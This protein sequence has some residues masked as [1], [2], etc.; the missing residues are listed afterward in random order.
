MSSIDNLARSD[1]SIKHGYALVQKIES[2][3]KFPKQFLSIEEIKNVRKVIPFSFKLN[4]IG[5][6]CKVPN[7]IKQIIADIQQLIKNKDAKEIF[8]ITI[9][10]AYDYK[11]DLQ[12]YINSNADYNRG[13][14]DID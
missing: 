11:K 10:I 13:Q 3:I 8:K 5:D 12:R 9:A 4:L 2:L 1:N 14:T 6:M 7:N